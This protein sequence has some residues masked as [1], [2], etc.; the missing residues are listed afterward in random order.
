MR[1]LM[2]FLDSDLMTECL[3]I[4]GLSFMLVNIMIPAIK[5]TTPNIIHVAF[6]V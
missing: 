1:D 2:P 5:A 3:E 6:Q 4:E